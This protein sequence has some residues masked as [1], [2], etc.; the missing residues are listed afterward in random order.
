MVRFQCAAVL[1]ALPS[2]CA[3]AVTPSV[4]PAARVF[5]DLLAAS[6]LLDADGSVWLSAQDLQTGLEDMHLHASIAAP[7]GVTHPSALLPA[8]IYSAEPLDVTDLVL[9]TLPVVLDAHPT[10]LFMAEQTLSND[11]FHESVYFGGATRDANSLPFSALCRRLVGAIVLMEALLALGRDEHR[12]IACWYE[13]ACHT[14]T[15]TQT[16]WT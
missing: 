15:H 7:E 3:V 13:A 2:V 14:H 6:D 4:R 12:Q 8:H 11:A 1:V 9:T 10:F 16:G 5:S